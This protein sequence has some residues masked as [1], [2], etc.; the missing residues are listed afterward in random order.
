MFMKKNISHHEK[1]SL[2]IAEYELNRHSPGK[3]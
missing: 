1:N 2:L 3:E